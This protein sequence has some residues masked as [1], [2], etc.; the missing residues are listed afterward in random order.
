ML[1]KDFLETITYDAI[2]DVEVFDGLNWLEYSSQSKACVHQEFL[3]YK[4]NKIFA[5]EEGMFLVIL[6]KKVK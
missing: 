2:V 5:Q 4:V 3:S 6:H 1:F